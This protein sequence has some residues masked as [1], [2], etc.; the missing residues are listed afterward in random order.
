M[1]V[2]IPFVIVAS[3]LVFP[4]NA[5]TQE[6]KPSQ[7][8]GLWIK[9]QGTPD[10][11]FYYKDKPLFMTGPIPEIEAFAYEWGSK[12]FQHDKWFKWM[13]TYGLSYGRVYP[14]SGAF[15]D[16]LMGEDRIYP[17]HVVRR[18]NG[19]PVFDLTKF[20][21]SY[22]A[23]MARVISECARRD[24]VLHL[25][26]YQ[27]CYFAGNVW[28]DCFFNPQNNVNN[29]D[30]GNY[31]RKGRIT[32]YD[33]WQKS[34]EDPALWKLHAEYVTRI[35]DAIG[36]NKNVL[37]DLMNEPGEWEKKRNLTTFGVPKMWVDRTLDV[38][39]QW[40]KDK[41][42]TLIKGLYI[43]FKGCEFSHF[44]HSHPRLDY[45][46]AHGEEIFERYNADCIK[47]RK[48]Y[49]KPMI[50]AHNGGRIPPEQK[51]WLSGEDYPRKRACQ[52]LCLMQKVQGL[53]VYAK[54]PLKLDLNH[55]NIQTYAKQ[56]KILHDFVKGIKDYEALRDAR[57]KIA[58]APGVYKYALESD[59]E[60]LVYLHNKKYKTTI[61]AGEKLSLKNLK[62]PDGKMSV[63]IL[64]P[65]SGK[66]S[67]RA[68]VVKDGSMSLELPQFYEDVVV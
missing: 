22:W 8:E 45:L 12:T 51:I 11:I 32:G 49:K 54:Y 19:R 18:E 26:I 6:Q 52:W 10:A 9:H 20:N 36:H 43:Q 67:R 44:A 66:S 40:E 46:I 4:D 64:H 29:F 28:K 34:L 59:K 2:I 50:S 57:P 1:K 58:Q 16:T 17:F 3:I 61:P 53:G 31:K 30:L 60:V 7:N 47:Y 27:R 68:M 35:L 41:D 55:P 23:N 25:Q 62:I 65:E 15:D 24:I 48:Q 21:D 38:I 56:S 13:K 37:L 42:I 5:Y 63:L 14:E 39:E 33:Y